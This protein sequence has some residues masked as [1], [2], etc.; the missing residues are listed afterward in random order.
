MS[1]AVGIRTCGVAA[2]MAGLSVLICG[3]VWKGG[4]KGAV[5]QGSPVG[6]WR[7]APHHVRV[8][9]STRFTQEASDTILEARIELRDEMGDPVKGVGRFRLELFARA[10]SGGAGMGQRLYSWDVSVM[11]LDDQRRFY[12]PI[13]RAY[14][15]R[16][17]LDDAHTARRR[18]HLQV[19]FTSSEGQRFEAQTSLPVDLQTIVEGL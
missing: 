4:Y 11:T 16:L 6:V 17:K 1:V 15:F 5:D 19:T 13:T 8:Y 10:R 3:C 12:D 18:T 14:L 7:V 2:R 9:P